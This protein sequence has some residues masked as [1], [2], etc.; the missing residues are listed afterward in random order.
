MGLARLNLNPAFALPL[1]WDEYGYGG[2]YTAVKEVV[3]AWEQRPPRAHLGFGSTCGVHTSD[4]LDF[5]RLCGEDG[6]DFVF[7]F[8]G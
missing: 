8:F 7:V 6:V 3:G 4:F 2:G 5:F 1:M